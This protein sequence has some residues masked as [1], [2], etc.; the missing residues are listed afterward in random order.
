MA[1]NPFGI[2][3][4]DVPG[5]L[6]TYAGM[7][8]QSLQDAY[9]QA[10]FQRQQTQDARADQE[11]TRAQRA[12]DLIA[13]GA[14]PEDVIA[15]DPATGFQ[16]ATHAAAL[17]KAQREEQAKRADDVGSAALYLAQLP[18]KDMAAQWNGVIDKLV[19]EGYSDLAAYKGKPD[20][21][22]LGP[23]IAASQDAV[24]AYAAHLKDSGDAAERARHDRFMEGIAGGNLDLSRKREARV[25]KWGPQPLLGTIG[26]V[27]P[28][29]D[30]TGADL[31][32]KY[33]GN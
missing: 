20:R 4:V 19:G 6:S 15:A 31:D 13:Q 10:A 28:N 27:N 5:L 25:T 8:R 29:A 26:N 32:A 21:N 11:Y 14:K 16:Y 18:D 1:S 22:T 30:P 7:K 12:R 23:I 17:T 24:K 33:G 2:T 9:T 3:Q